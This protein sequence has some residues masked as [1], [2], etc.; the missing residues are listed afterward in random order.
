MCSDHEARRGQRGR[1]MDRGRG[2][3]PPASAPPIPMKRKLD[4][5]SDI[6][7]ALDAYVSSDDDYQDWDDFVVT[8][9]LEDI[10]SSKS[11]LDDLDDPDPDLSSDGGRQKKMQ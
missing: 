7:T 6:R 8:K 1:S 2:R 9:E 11:D 3:M 10:P 5:S 4:K